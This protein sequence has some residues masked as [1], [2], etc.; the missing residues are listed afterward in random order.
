VG[1]LLLR[2]VVAVGIAAVAVAFAASARRGRALR[3]RPFDPNGLE[4][5]LHF[6]SSLTCSSCE[7]ARAVL[8]AS[9]RP[10]TEHSF[11]SNDTM[12][13]DNRIERV[14]AVAYV[15]ADGRTAWIAEGV[16]SVG[17]LDRWLGP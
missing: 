8:V 6:F 7:R 16:P 4:S 5:G 10:F 11:E 9:S 13:R 17:A 15:S 2:L 3:R 14:P 1:D 12:L